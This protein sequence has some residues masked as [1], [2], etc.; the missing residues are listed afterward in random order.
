MA[1]IQL[2]GS[3]GTTGTAI[4]GRVTVTYPSDADYTLLVSEYTNQ[5]LNVTS[6]VSLT[7]T[8]NLIVPVVEGVTYIIQNN[9]SGGQS[10]QVIGTTGTGITIMNGSTVSVVCDGTNYL[11][12]S[13]GSSV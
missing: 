12:S 6:S 4:L 10:I 9:T 5:F 13:G 2:G 11:Q 7:A 3:V 1:D 8:R